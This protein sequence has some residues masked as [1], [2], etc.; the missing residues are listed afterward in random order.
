MRVRC[1]TRERAVRGAAQRGGRVDRA[2]TEARLGQQ[3]NKN[4]YLQNVFRHDVRAHA[5]VRPQHRG[6]RVQVVHKLPH[7]S[8]TQSGDGIVREGCRDGRKAWI[9]AKQ[10]QAIREAPRVPAKWCQRGRRPRLPPTPACARPTPRTC[11]FP[12]LPPPRCRACPRRP[13]PPRCAAPPGR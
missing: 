6:D 12:A 1:E 3:S 2:A 7:L 8:Q 5:V 4:A 11:V 9:M 13:P 10:G